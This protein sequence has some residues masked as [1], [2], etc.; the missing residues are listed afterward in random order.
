[1]IDKG[2]MPGRVSDNPYVRRSKVCPLCDGHKDTG[3][4]ACWS[5]FKARGMRYGNKDAEKIIE[6]T[7]RHLAACYSD[8]SE[9]QLLEA[10]SFFLNMLPNERH[11]GSPH[12]FATSYDLAAALDRYFRKGA[13]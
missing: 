2:N 7:E 5:C 12:G 13:A 8:L 10:C 3:L 9:R 11:L 6:R 4:V 1:M